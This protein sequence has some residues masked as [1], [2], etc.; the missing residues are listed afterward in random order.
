MRSGL[1]AA[2]MGIG[3]IFAAFGATILVITIFSRMND[4][5]LVVPAELSLGTLSVFVGGAMFLAGFL[6]DRVGRRSSE[7]V[8]A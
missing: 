8:S 6:L 4:W 5:H 2:L 3:G 7:R 1:I